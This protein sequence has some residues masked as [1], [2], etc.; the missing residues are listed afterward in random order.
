MAKA[1]A[2]VAGKLLSTAKAP[3]S[4]GGRVSIGLSRDTMPRNWQRQLADECGSEE[5]E[6]LNRNVMSERFEMRIDADLKEKAEE[7][8]KQKEIS[9]AELIK[10]YLRRITKA[11]A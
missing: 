10:R 9:L 8:A 2:R 5:L 6:R 4:F 1:D 3:I 7:V 11:N